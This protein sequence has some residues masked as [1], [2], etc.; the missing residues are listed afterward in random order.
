[1]P[2][3]CCGFVFLPRKGQVVVVYC[4]LKDNGSLLIRLL[5]CLNHLC[6]C[7]CRQNCFYFITIK[8]VFHTLGALVDACPKPA[9]VHT[10]LRVP[11]R[12]LPL[13]TCAHAHT[14]LSVFYLCV[15]ALRSV[16]LVAYLGTR[17]RSVLLIITPCKW[18]TCKGAIGTGV[19]AFV[20]CLRCNE[21][22]LVQRVVLC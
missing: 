21:D 22:W 9:Y 7:V 14:H 19:Y 17:R 20:W 13:E 6:V 15:N 12:C 5:W 18:V 16:W 2:S 11:R 3:L 10:S 8:C 4:Q 1:M